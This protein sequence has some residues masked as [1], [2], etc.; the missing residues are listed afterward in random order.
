M[1]IYKFINKV[2]KNKCMSG[3]LADSSMKVPSAIV[4]LKKAISSLSNNYNYDP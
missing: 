4:N 3:P 1:K 2:K